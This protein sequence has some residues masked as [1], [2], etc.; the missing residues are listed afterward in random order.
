V[1]WDYVQ[2]PLSLGGLGVKN[3]ELMGHAL[4]LRCLWLQRTDPS[5]PC[6][7]MPVHE[8]EPTQAFFRA[9]VT[10]KVRNVASTLFWEERWLDG[11]GLQELASDLLAIVLVQHMRT[12]QSALVDNAWLSDVQGPL[13]VP[14]IMQYVQVRE[15]V[16]SFQLME[17]NNTVAW[18]WCASGQFSS[19]SAY[20]AMFLGQSTTQGA[21]QLWKASAP[22]EHNFFLWLAIHDRCWTNGR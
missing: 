10:I 19:S 2:R 21:K 13:T 12:V 22:S 15:L 1:A 16:D 14:V 8:D 4:R 17:G 18:H 6:A 7:S 11:Q 9:S 3:L 20:D 5:K